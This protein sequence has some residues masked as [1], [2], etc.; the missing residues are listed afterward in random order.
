MKQQKKIF[1]RYENK[2]DIVSNYFGL[3][4]YY[5]L[6]QSADCT[7]DKALIEK[8]VKY[9]KL[10]P[11]NFPHPRY[12]FEAYRVGGIAKA[13]LFLKG[14]MPES[15]DELRKYALLTMSAPHSKEGIISNPNDTGRIWIDTVAFVTTYM[16]YTGKALGEESFIDYAADLCLKSYVPRNFRRTMNRILTAR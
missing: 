4:A 13:W 5:A 2:H 16:L 6:A 8:C 11:D 10:Y 7:D 1:E 12:N 3:L 14:Y 9:L 15:A